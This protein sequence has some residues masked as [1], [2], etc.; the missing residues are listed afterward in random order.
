MSGLNFD[1]NYA[2]NGVTWYI[3]VLLIAGYFIWFFLRRSKKTYI[4]LICPL[5][6]LLIFPYLFRTYGF[7]GYHW[8]KNSFILNS[9]LLR[10]IADMNLG[11]LA[12]IF[13]RKYTIPGRFRAKALSFPCLLAG[14]IVMPAFFYRTHWDFL[15]VLLIFIG[16]TAG[17]CCKKVSFRIF[18]SRLFDRWAMITPAIYLNH[19]M[20]RGFFHRLM[21]ELTPAVYLIWFV[22]ITVYSIFTFWLVGKAGLLVKKHFPAFVTEIRQPSEDGEI[23]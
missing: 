1:R 9:A 2:V 8:D 3:S 12:C 16:I 10:G 18:E 6:I 20:F 4:E 5:S 17:F 13:T 11:V 21:P 23:K 22:F 7:V 15:F 19:K 14:G